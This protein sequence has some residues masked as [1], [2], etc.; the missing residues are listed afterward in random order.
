MDSC[1]SKRARTAARRCAFFYRR[2]RPPVSIPRADGG[3][4]S[5]LHLEAERLRAP[6]GERRAAGDR[7]RGRG[8]QR[9]QATRVEDCAVT[10]TERSTALRVSAVGLIQA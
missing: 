9:Q 4:I 1:W 8:G 6:R 3:R 5:P 10:A 7:R 2:T